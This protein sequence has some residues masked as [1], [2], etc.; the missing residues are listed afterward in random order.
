MGRDLGIDPVVLEIVEERPRR[1]GGTATRSCSSGAARATPTPPPT[2]TRSRGCSPTTAGSGMVEPAFAGVAQPI[3]T[4]ALER[5]R[6]LGA[7]RVAVVPFFLFTGVLVPRIYAEAAAYAAEHPELEVVGGRAPRPGPAARAAGA[8]ALPRGADRRRADELRPLHLPRPAARL[9]G[10]GRH[11]DLADAARR[12]SR[13]RLAPLAAGHARAARSCPP[14]RPAV[15]RASARRSVAL[16]ELRVRLP[17]RHAGAQRASTCGSRRASGWPLLGPNGAGKT[18][19]ALAACGALEDLTRHRHR[20]R[21]DARARDPPRDPPPRRDRLPGRR[22]PAVHADRRGG[23]R[24]RPRQPG[25]ARRRAAR[26]G[27]RGAGGRA[28]ARARRAARRTR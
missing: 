1:A 26:A 20:R 27:G 2:S 14:L 28:P 23:R 22:R 15:G 16:D 19:L 25:T 6:R 7:K 3:V 21:D 12:R 9:R 18:T 24:V 4:E 10:Q 11:A 5:C 17:G 13:A 8:G